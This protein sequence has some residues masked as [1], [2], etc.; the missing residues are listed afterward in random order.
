MM[1]DITYDHRVQPVL[2]HSLI[3]LPL[4]FTD[5]LH[6]HS[7]LPQSN[8]ANPGFSFASVNVSRYS[9]SISPDWSMCPRQRATAQA[10]HFAEFENA[11]SAWSPDVDVPKLCSYITQERELIPPLVLRRDFALVRDSV[12]LNLS[13]PIKLL[14]GWMKRTVFSVSI[15]RASF[16]SIFEM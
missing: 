5:C 6:P 16:T 11:L 14:Q 4:D 1:R 15:V 13:V 12:T 10:R 8:Q 7:E 2:V 3:S 9:L